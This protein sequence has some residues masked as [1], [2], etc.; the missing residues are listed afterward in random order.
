MEP[1][2]K[3]QFLEAAAKLS[4]ASQRSGDELLAGSLEASKESAFPGPDCLHPDEVATFQQSGHLAQDRLE[5]ANACA[6][7]SSMIQAAQPSPERIRAFREKVA[8]TRAEADKEAGLLSWLPNAAGAVLVAVLAI[9]IGVQQFGL[10]GPRP[11]SSN[12]ASIGGEPLVQAIITSPVELKTPL[13]PKSNSEELTR[14]VAAAGALANQ[15]FEFQA[16]SVDWTKFLPK[17][18]SAWDSECKTLAVGLLANAVGFSTDAGTVAAS[19]QNVAESQKGG[20]KKS[21]AATIHVNDSRDTLRFICRPQAGILYTAETPLHE[22]ALSVSN[23]LK[24]A[25]AE[26][27]PGDSQAPVDFD[28]SV[29]LDKNVNLRWESKAASALK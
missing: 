11:G 16:T 28:K 26:V 13:I 20:A 21:S 2:R 9:G 4:Q 17:Q 19:L 25:K 23:Y 7:C 3:P 15:K 10:L 6:M 18:R 29:A 22:T 27:K 1:E 8:E 5:H 12:Q 24:R 14:A